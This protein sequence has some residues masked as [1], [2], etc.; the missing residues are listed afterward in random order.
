MDATPQPAMSLSQFNSS[1]QEF[2]SK[3]AAKL[4]ETYIGRFADTTSE[5]YKRTSVVS[6]FTL[7]AGATKA[8]C[9]IV[10]EVRQ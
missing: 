9:G 2:P 3:D 7:M 4:R 1:V 8:I 5:F 10:F 6:N